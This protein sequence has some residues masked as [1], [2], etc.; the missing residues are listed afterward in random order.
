MYPCRR[1]EGVCESAVV[2]PLILTTALDGGERSAV[3]HTRFII[4][5]GVPGRH[6]VEGWV[7]PEPV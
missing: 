4:T 6:C 5:E 2:L 3:L 7:S 1:Y